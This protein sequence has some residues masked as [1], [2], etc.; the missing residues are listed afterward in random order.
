MLNQTQPTKTF[1]EDFLAVAYHKFWIFPSKCL[2]P[3]FLWSQTG[4]FQHDN[5]TCTFA[6]SNSSFGQFTLTKDCLGDHDITINGFT[7][8]WRPIE[9]HSWEECS[10]SHTRRQTGGSV[11]LTH[12]ALPF[13]GRRRSPVPGAWTQHLTSVYCHAADV[14]AVEQTWG[15]C[16]EATVLHIVKLSL[17]IFRENSD[18]WLF[19]WCACVTFTFRPRLC[20]VIFLC[21]LIAFL[22]NVSREQCKCQLLVDV[23]TG[24]D[25]S[26]CR[27]R[28]QDLTISRHPVI[29]EPR[30]LVRHEHFHE[31]MLCNAIMTM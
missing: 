6:R 29:W 22:L 15:L 1:G 16:I 10:S 18:D 2:L 31:L 7:A 8:N 21:F 24:C 28:F 27:E 3:G 23:F 14:K 19:V 9:C 11:V 5:F 12:S 20:C 4:L 30:R 26:H 17:F 25:R 13:K